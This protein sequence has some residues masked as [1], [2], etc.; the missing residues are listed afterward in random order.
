MNIA[1]WFTHK[2]FWKL[3]TQRNQKNNLNRYNLSLPNQKENV[4][5]NV[6]RYSIIVI[7][8]SAEKVN[9]N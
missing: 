2:N 4:I 9:T 7:K 3:Y 8:L 5:I 6:G 1:D